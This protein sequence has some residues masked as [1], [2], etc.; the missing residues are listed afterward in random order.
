MMTSMMNTNNISAIIAEL[1]EEYEKQDSANLINEA[2]LYNHCVTAL[3]RF[4]NSITQEMTCL[5]D[6]KKGH[7]EFPDNYVQLNYLELYEPHSYEISNVND[8]ALLNN[9]FYVERVERNSSWSECDPSIKT[10]TENTIT[11]TVHVGM[12]YIKMRY[13]NK[14][15]IFLRRKIGQRDGVALHCPN[16]KIIEGCEE[17]EINGRHI[18]TSFDE[19]T[20]YVN[21]LGLPMDENGDIDIPESSGDCLNIYV[22][23][24][25]EA[26]LLKKLIAQ[27]D[28]G[29]G[30][31]QIYPEVLRKEEI[32][33]KNAA[34]KVKFSQLRPKKILRRFRKLNRLESITYEV[35]RGWL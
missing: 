26:K 10:V 12:G 24:Y 4:G 30:I 22:K 5:V 33:L 23:L 7:G 14:R 28:A 21:Y 8:E 20:L 3:R 16:N 9:K 15:H 34:G 2:F 27:E 32:A 17:A 19:G 11:E 29:Q 35:S 13:H 18:M 1:K 31:M 6:I 25:A